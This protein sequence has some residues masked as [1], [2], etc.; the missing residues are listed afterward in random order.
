MNFALLVLRL[1]VGGLF[2]GHGTQKLLGWFG[3]HGLDGTAAYF[4]TTGL[5]PGRINAIAAGVAEVTAG[6]LL[7]AGFLTPLAAA[8]ITAVMVTAVWTVH[9]PNGLWITDG[10]YEYNLVLAAIAF[11]ITAVGAGSWS[12][13]AAWNLDL[14]GTSWAFI[15]LAAGALGGWI[16]AIA[17]QHGRSR[18][19]R[20]TGTTAATRT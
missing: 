10:G 5:K 18:S 2:V 17:P 11:A 19:S 15:E 12:L 14:D 13:D 7:A 8:L 6:V 4:E 9:R 1:I 3:G 20:P 16:A